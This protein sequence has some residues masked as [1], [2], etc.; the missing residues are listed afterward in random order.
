MIIIIIIIIIINVHVID[1]INYYLDPDPLWN[2]IKPKLTDTHMYT[3][4][5]YLHV[6][7]NTYIFYGET[8]KKAIDNN[9]KVLRKLGGTKLIKQNFFRSKAI[10]KN[11]ES[12]S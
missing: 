11:T 3:V 7:I 8:R 10:E 6:S 2:M 5:N 9:L 4:Y 12:I 1:L